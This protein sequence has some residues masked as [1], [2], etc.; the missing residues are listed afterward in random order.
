M[1]AHTHTHAHIQLKLEQ[2]GQKY[3]DTGPQLY[4]LETNKKG[5]FAGKEK[6]CNTKEQLAII[7]K[8]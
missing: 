4:F 7:K 5:Q 1:L 2:N 3:V 8:E 6:G